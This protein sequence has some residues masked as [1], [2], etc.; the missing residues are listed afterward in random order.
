M[1]SLT[2]FLSFVVSLYILIGTKNLH[3]TSNLLKRRNK[4]STF[5][6]KTIRKWT[7]VQCERNQQCLYVGRLSMVIQLH[8]ISTIRLI[9]L[10]LLKTNK[11]LNEM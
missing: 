1:I 2:F 4:T 10:A 11:T 9:C 3:Y 6:E 7:L 5:Y 8:L